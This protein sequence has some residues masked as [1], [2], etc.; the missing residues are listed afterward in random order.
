MPAHIDNSFDRLQDPFTRGPVLSMRPTVV[1]GKTSYTKATR[2]G[3]GVCTRNSGDGGHARSTAASPRPL[4][5]MFRYIHT[6]FLPKRAVSW[7]RC[8]PG[9]ASHQ[10]WAGSHQASDTQ[11]YR[12]LLR[13]GPV[14]SASQWWASR[15]LVANRRLTLPPHQAGLLTASS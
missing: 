10:I 12:T 3:R 11:L 7:H 8:G 2:L 15:R 13:D 5:N 1:M 14:S 9:H 6:R 4:L